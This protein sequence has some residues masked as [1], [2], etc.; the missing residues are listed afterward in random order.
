MKSA[1]FY[2]KVILEIKSDSKFKTMKPNQYITLSKAIEDLKEKGFTQ[3]LTI[4]TSG[5]MEIFGES[6]RYKPGEVKIQEFHRF[7]GMSSAGDS[8]IVYAL[9]TKDGVKG[10]LID[11]YGS[12]SSI[13][14]SEFMKKV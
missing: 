12:D 11:A 5:E 4:N 10:T 6:A 3:D 8:S 7:E 9:E 1:N 14:I 13:A 2:S